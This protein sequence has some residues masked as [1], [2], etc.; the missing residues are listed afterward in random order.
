LILAPVWQ[1][2]PSFLAL[3]AMYAP[4]GPSRKPL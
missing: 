4:Q 1:A 3:A 2:F